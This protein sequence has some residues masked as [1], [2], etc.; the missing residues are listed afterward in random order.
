M[1]NC[2]VARSIT[3]RTLWNEVA[4]KIRRQWR[5]RELCVSRVLGGHRDSRHFRDRVLGTEILRK[6][7]LS[8]H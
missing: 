1:E 7:D 5:R 8:R 3:R 6:Q 4:E 2:I